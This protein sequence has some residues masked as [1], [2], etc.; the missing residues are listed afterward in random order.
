MR[1]RF[2]KWL[3]FPGIIVLSFFLMTLQSTLFSTTP[4]TYFQPDG[5]LLVLLWI[6]TR[7]T[8]GEGGTLA[9]IL[10][11]CMELGSSAPRGLFMTHSMIFFLALHFLHH[12]LHILSKRALMVVGA[13]IAVLSKLLIL[14]LLFL[15]G[16]AANEWEHSLTF[17]LPTA[18]TH[19]LL[20]PLFFR[21][22]HRYD[23]W[24]MKNPNAEHQHEQDFFL[25]EEFI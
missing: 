19:A 25:D 14:F 5:V 13:S 9:L 20:A 8:F 24:T 6:S 12:N 3:N 7:R 16:K 1:T 15:M 11:Y 4:L 21:L 22:L 18:V 10:G 2:L 17:L 23:I